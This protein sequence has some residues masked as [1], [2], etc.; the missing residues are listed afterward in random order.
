MGKLKPKIFR[1][2]RARRDASMNGIQ[3][4]T[5]DKGRKIAVQIDIKKHG[6]VLQEFWDGLVVEARRNEKDIPFAEV[7]KSRVRKPKRP[8]G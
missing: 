6:A 4:V 2:E 7:R 8:H 1:F 5:D 3:F